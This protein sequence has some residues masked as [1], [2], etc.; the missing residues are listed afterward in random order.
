VSQWK[1]I[2]GNKI[3]N[4]II[5]FWE[6][7][8]WGRCW[9]L[10]VWCRKQ[11]KSGG[12]CLRFCKEKCVDACYFFLVECELKYGEFKQWKIFALSRDRDRDRDRVCLCSGEHVVPEDSGKIKRKKWSSCMRFLYILGFFYF[13]LEF[14]LWEKKVLIFFTIYVSATSFFSFSFSFFSKFVNY[15]SK[16]WN[17][18][19]FTPQYF[20][21]L[22]LYPEI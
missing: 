12:I 21:N 13:F 4:K 18:L 8:K 1:N 14:W 16:V 6:S 5:I 10:D 20:R 7:A 19:N 15:I 17:W 11:W 2:L 22:I 3:F 9:G